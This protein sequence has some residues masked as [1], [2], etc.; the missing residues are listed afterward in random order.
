MQEQQFVAT[1][2]LE[3]AADGARLVVATPSL[4]GALTRHQTGGATRHQ[5]DC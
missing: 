2:S 3:G 1:P 5:S 4:E